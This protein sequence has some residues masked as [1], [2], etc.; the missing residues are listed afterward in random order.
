MTQ[1]VQQRTGRTGFFIPRT[2]DQRTNPAVHHRAGTHHARLKRDIQRGIKQTIV[3]QHHSA[4]TKGHYFSVRSRIVTANR[5]VPP[6]PYHLVIVDK[7]G[8]HG[9][10]SLVPGALG[11]RKR[12]AHPVFMIAF[13]VAQRLILQSKSGRHYTHPL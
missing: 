12:M 1:H 5:A 11:K 7:H 3:L 9:H 13:R 10:F 8:T 2:K 6:F 4:L